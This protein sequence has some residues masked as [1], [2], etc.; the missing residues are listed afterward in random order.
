MALPQDG[1]PTVS[2][3]AVTATSVD[4]PP[5]QPA[6][7]R[8]VLRNASWLTGG[9]WL[10]DLLSFGLFVVLARRFGADGIGRFAYGSVIA[11]FVSLF[12]GLGLDEYGIRELSRLPA[13]E[14]RA[15][16]GRL[17]ATQLV[18]CVAVSAGLGLFLLITHPSAETIALVLL[19]SAQQ[20]TMTVARTF[21]VP[22]FADQRM[23]RFA[24]AEFAC[25]G[26]G[27]LLAPILV[28]A[29]RSSLPMALIGYPVGGVVLLGIALREARLHLGRLQL[30]VSRVELVRLIR[31]AWAFGAGEVVYMLYA[32]TDVVLL[33]WIAGDRVAG[34]YASSLKFYE[35]GSR[36]VYFLGV[37]A[38]PML[39]RLFAERSERLAAVAGRLLRAAFGA[40]TLLAWGVAFVV[41]V[42]LVPLLGP[43]FRSAEPVVR[44]MSALM[45]LTASEM[46]AVRLLLA[47][48]LEHT[49]VK[50]QVIGTL[51]NIGLDLALIPWLGIYG[52]IVAT[53][54]ALFVVN[55]LYIRPLER[56]LGP[57]PWRAA[58]RWVTPA[59]AAA[60]AS[61]AVVVRLRGSSRVLAGVTLVVFAAVALRGG[62]AWAL[63]TSST[64]LMPILGR[65]D[66]P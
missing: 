63:G 49:K 57:E 56:Q 11:S 55:A 23:E 39:T 44:T 53:T 26:G 19:L 52:A 7:S 66:R 9:R 29:A 30:Q 31:V 21:F 32:R 4:A 8:R 46:V 65:E 2:S 47:A 3:E 5:V 41:P 37:S 13:E 33:A 50:L 28:I 34:L 12:I 25:R 42:L 1:F 27:M 40:G 6:R 61:G 62:L 54:V 48:Q 64:N 59:I 60:A 43:E 18:L 58:L 14:G 38:Y 15:L 20:A 22:A 17:V 45:L 10:G 36:P 16:M 51:V 35:V 24:A